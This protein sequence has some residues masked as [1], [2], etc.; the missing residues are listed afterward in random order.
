M[1]NEMTSPN[2]PAA[3]C[4]RCA[5]AVTWVRDADQTLLVDAEGGGHWSLRGAEAAVWDWLVLAY[6][7]ERIVRFLSLLL[8]VPAGQVGK[9]LCSTLLAWQDAGIVQAVGESYRGKPG[10]QRRL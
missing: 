1:T 2:G 6:P 7:Y 4:Y 8:R 3:I 10:D 9:V 5:P